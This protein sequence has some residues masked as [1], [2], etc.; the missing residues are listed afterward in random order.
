MFKI[1]GVY[2]SKPILPIGTKI[3]F[4][5]E[6]QRYTVRASNAAYT[7]ITKP[8]NLLRTVKY[9]I[10]DFHEQVRGPE[11]LIFSLGAE[12]DRQIARMM[13]R[14][15]YGTS[16]ISHRRRCALDIESVTF[17]DGRIHKEDR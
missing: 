12:T 11:D 2:H 5:R 14:M 16:E 9:S 7:I 6:K 1:A 10:I 3:K 17:P 15:T 13:D 8:F 4:Y